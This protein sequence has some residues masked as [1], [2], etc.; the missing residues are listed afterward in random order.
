MPQNFAD[1]F[2]Y[3]QGTLHKFWGLLTLVACMGCCCE[4]DRK[5][6]V[7]LLQQLLSP[8]VLDQTILI[9]VPLNSA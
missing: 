7:V 1:L 6:K 2:Y 3:V 4:V 9:L 8:C 5:S